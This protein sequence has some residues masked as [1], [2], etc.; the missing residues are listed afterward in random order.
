MATK[1]GSMPTKTY[2][3][4]RRCP[5]FPSSTTTDP[6]RLGCETAIFPAFEGFTHSLRP[7]RLARARGRHRA[8][9]DRLQNR[10]SQSHDVFVAA[11]IEAKSLH[12]IDIHIG[13][14]WADIRFEAKRL[15]IHRRLLFSLAIPE[16]VPWT[17]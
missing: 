5:R 9:R 14:H 15:G 7:A 8:A 17:H 12:M 11:Q 1:S 6:R 4:T 16:L 3:S 2:G 10:I 13:E